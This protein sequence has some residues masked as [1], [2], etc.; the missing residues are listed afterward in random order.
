MENY[1]SRD[2]I[3]NCIYSL[4]TVLCQQ[5]LS[6]LIVNLQIQNICQNSDLTNLTK[7]SML[8]LLFITNQQL[9]YLK[10]IIFIHCPKLIKITRYFATISFFTLLHYLIQ[11]GVAFSLIRGQVNSLTRGLDM[12]L[13]PCK[14][15]PNIMRFS[16]V[17]LAIN[18]SN[19]TLFLDTFWIHFAYKGVENGYPLES[20]V[21]QYLLILFLITEVVLSFD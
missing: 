11:K 10:S 13:P 7:A 4:L 12:K 18:P 17:F 14:R 5:N 3:N 15:V 2:I 8:R 6:I 1:I 19:T 20:E 16:P 21:M 9:V